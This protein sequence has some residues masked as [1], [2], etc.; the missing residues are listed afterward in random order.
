MKHHSGVG[1]WHRGWPCAYP[2]CIVGYGWGR[3]GGALGGVGEVLFFQQSTTS[4]PPRLKG[5]H[6]NMCID[7]YI[8]GKH[9]HTQA[10][11]ARGHHQ[12]V[13][14]TSVLICTLFS[15]CLFQSR[16]CRHCHGDCWR[17]VS[18]W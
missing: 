7:N 18:S 2:Q 16:F 11:S 4:D 8:L 3:G 14:N 1:R 12:S 17:L 6:T 5:R 10:L 9:S 15:R 13:P